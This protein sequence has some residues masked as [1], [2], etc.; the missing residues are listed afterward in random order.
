MEPARL[1][2]T[3]AADEKHFRG[4]AAALP[5]PEPKVSSLVFPSQWLNLSLR[6]QATPLCRLIA[7]WKLGPAYRASTR[8]LTGEGG[9]CCPERR[10]MVAE[11]QSR[12]RKR[13]RC[14]S[15]SHAGRR[16]AEVD[17]PR[18]ETTHHEISTLGGWTQP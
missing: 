10:G 8:L 2:L 7:W 9:I 18:S 3:P 4:I 1:Q 16:S 17:N 13:A 14:A 11:A 5:C 12:A 6:R 15:V